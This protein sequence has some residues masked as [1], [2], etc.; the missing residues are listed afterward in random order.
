MNRP[1]ITR[2]KFKRNALRDTVR[3]I[4]KRRE[5]NSLPMIWVVVGITGYFLLRALYGYLTQ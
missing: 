3:R 1:S 2:T 5:D 4:N